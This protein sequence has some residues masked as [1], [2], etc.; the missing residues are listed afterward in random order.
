MTLLAELGLLLLV[1][2]LFGFPRPRRHPESLTSALVSKSPILVEP[3]PTENVQSVQR[4][5][6]SPGRF[7]IVTAAAI[8]AAGALAASGTTQTDGQ[9]ASNN[10]IT[11]TTSTASPSETPNA[12]HRGAACFSGRTV[13]PQDAVIMHVLVHFHGGAIIA[14]TAEANYDAA[15]TYDAGYRVTDEAVKSAAGENLCVVL[16]THGAVRGP[17]IP[18]LEGEA[19]YQIETFGPGGLFPYPETAVY[20]NPAVF[21]DGFRSAG[22]SGTSYS[23][24]GSYTWDTPYDSFEATVNFGGTPKFVT[25][26]RGGVTH[27]SATVKADGSGSLALLA[28][29]AFSGE[30]TATLSWTCE[31]VA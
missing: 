10:G 26:F 28:P 29:S 13:D 2:W 22:G 24:P 17:G 4:G 3:L 11:S 12:G 30:D 18:V 7:R 25:G 8:V 14:D 19:N 23:G 16:A 20:S 5:S 27:V 6:N 21:W 9:I 31:S 15:C 1:V